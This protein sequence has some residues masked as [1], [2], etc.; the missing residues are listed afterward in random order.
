VL[1][2]AFALALTACGK[3]STR[4]SSNNAARTLVIDR[5]FDLKTADPGREFEVSG[6]IIVHALYDTLLTF[7]GS[8]VTKPVPSLAESYQQSADGKS[9]TFKLRS[10]VKFSDNTPLT[11]ADVAFSLNRVRNLKGNPS[12]L[13]EGVTATAQGEDTVVLTSTKPNPA[14]SYLLPNPA[15]GV[16]NSKVVK[17]HGG[18]DAAGADKTDKAETFLNQ[19]SAGSGPY[20]LESFNT[21]SQTV[22]KANP[23]YWV[24]GSPR[25]PAWSCVTCRPTPSGSTCRRVTASSPSTSRPTR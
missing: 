3:S 24:P 16:V 21:T 13:M 14:L 7:E 19:T 2:A 8:D 1:M 20:V 10:G 9:F 11:A 25:T 5:S 18:T 4:S 12:F 15:L 6:G 23:N 22:I 17:E